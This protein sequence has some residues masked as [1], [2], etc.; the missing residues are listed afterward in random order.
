VV[1]PISG[2]VLKAFQ[3][4][5]LFMEN[6]SLTPA[7]CAARL[8]WPRATCHRLL[9]TLREVGALELNEGGHYNLSLRLFEI[10][11]QAPVRRRLCDRGHLPLQLLS[12]ET[13]MTSHLGA[14]S[15]ANLVFLDVV[16]GRSF[17]LATRVGHRAP[18]H[19]TSIGKL[20]LAH[21][22]EKVIQNVTERG[23]TRFTDATIVRPADLLRQLHE[24]REKDVSYEREEI[25]KGTS[26]IAVPIRLQGRVIGAIS[27]AFPIG[28]P[29]WQQ[30]SYEQQLRKSRDVIERGLSW[31]SILQWGLEDAPKAPN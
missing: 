18:L 7:D 10:G 13:G 6:G 24:I 11:A 21:A 19:A 3:V 25:H 20:L 12:E 16:P 27:L 23:L 30:N 14:R 9:L 5:D 4:L 17:K 26:C 2:T 28:R 31:Q 22:P 15:G 1:T 29:V 8:G